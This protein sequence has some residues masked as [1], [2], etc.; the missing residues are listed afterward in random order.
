MSTLGGYLHLTNAVYGTV[1]AGNSI[2]TVLRRSELP[3][4][5]VIWPGY[6]KQSLEVLQSLHGDY[7][8]NKIINAL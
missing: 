7:T 4:L 3:K 1:D 5:E 8:L 2:S 6:R